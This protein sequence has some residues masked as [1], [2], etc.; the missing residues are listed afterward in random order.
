VQDKRDQQE[1]KSQADGADDDLPGIRSKWMRQSV[2]EE[3]HTQ[4]QKQRDIAKINEPKVCTTPARAG[5]PGVKN[6]GRENRRGV[7]LF[8]R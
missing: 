7:A 3:F 4:R 2:V 1:R 8:K 5:R 6:P